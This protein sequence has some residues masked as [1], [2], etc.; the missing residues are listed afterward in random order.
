MKKLIFLFFFTFAL[1]GCGDLSKDIDVTDT[2][3]TDDFNGEN[4]PDGDYEVYQYFIQIFKVPTKIEVKQGRG[5]VYLEVSGDNLSTIHKDHPSFEKAKAL[6][7]FYGDTSYY[8]GSQPFAN[9]PLAYPI[10]KITIRCESD[11]DAKH[12]AG[13]PLDDV[14]KLKYYTYYEFIKNGYEIPADI[15]Q[16]NR[17]GNLVLYV[18]NFENIHADVATL[19]ELETALTPRVHFDSAPAEPGEYNFVLETTINGKVFTS[20]F[21]YTFE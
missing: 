8:K 11:F 9:S 2:D 15:P 18:L 4:I 1:C 12:P 19:I 5:I 16:E 14:V 7:E 10:D 20:E 13:V 17:M 6:A 3:V 21:S